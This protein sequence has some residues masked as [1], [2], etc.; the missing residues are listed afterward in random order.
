MKISRLIKELEK[1]YEEYGDV[2]TGTRHYP[3]IC[4]V[5]HDTWLWTEG[6][7][8]RKDFGGRYII[9]VIR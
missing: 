8:V 2:D 4:R 6:V 3:T 5:D 7:E 1:I 9:A